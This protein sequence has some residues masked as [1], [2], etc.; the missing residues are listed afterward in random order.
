MGGAAYVLHAQLAGVLGHATLGARLTI[1]LG[2][3]A[4]GIA[5]Y[6]G[7]CRAMKVEELDGFVQA[8]RRRVL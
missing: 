2:P 8:F 1:T 4:A 5:V 6:A 7:L 3:I